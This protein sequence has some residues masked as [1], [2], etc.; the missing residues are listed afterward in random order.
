MRK[1]LI[2]LLTLFV[3]ALMNVTALAQTDRGTI[4]GRV[5]DNTGAA[6]AGASI[7]VTNTATGASS[8]GT[9][10]AEGLYTIPALTVGTY[11]VK[12]EKTGFK[13]AEVSNVVITVGSTIGTDVALEVGQV[14][15]TVQVVSDIAQ[16]QTEN[17]KISSAV[18]NKQI[19]QLP[20]VVSGTMRSP[21]DLTLLT[22]ESKPLGLG[23][24]A[25]TGGAGYNSTFSLGGGQ[26]GTWGITLDGASSGTSRFG[27]TE[28]ASLN[29]PSIDAITEFSVDTNGFKAESGRA[30]GGSLSFV[31][32]SGT[33]EF[34]GTAF[35]FLRNDYFDAR[36]FFEDNGG[37]DPSGVN[38]R[39]TKAILKQHDYGGTLGGPVWI[40]KIYNGKNKT[41]FFG[42]FE[43][44]R[45]RS[46][47]GEF[48]TSVPTPEMYQGDFSR[49]VDSTGKLLPIYDP[50][51][52][53]ANPNYNSAAPVSESN[54]RWDS[55][56][57]C[58]PLGLLRSGRNRRT[59]RS[60]SP[61]SNPSC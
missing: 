19:D 12:V 31:S 36:R 35:E 21:F 23:G 50:A 24:D 3:W 53:R 20:L 34:H 14:S 28:W 18:S 25:G 61:K 40:P 29:T 56:A 8:N 15:E 4:T 48:V 42:S 41:F 17:A 57:V 9:T 54:P 11:K 58:W 32:K 45:N 7:T 51:T 26:G 46:G 44:F 5:T 38:K 10:N 1:R 47:A 43:L 60:K 33:N 6:V 52:T 27:S 37:L 22:P 49:W 59:I 2:V 39:R 13:K 30:Q 16:L 55:R